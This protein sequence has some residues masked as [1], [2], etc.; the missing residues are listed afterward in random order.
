MKDNN[1][2]RKILID[3][4]NEVIN[5]IKK[6]TLIDDDDIKEIKNEEKDI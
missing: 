2:K 6:K 3:D 4:D 5:K 1:I